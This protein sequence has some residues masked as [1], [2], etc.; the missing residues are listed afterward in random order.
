[1]SADY[2]P[3]TGA[4]FPYAVVVQHGRGWIY[5]HS[6]HTTEAEANTRARIT[7]EYFNKR[8]GRGLKGVVTVWQLIHS[9]S[10]ETPQAP[11]STSA[12]NSKEK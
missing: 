10:G 9:H 8:P 11:V 4:E 7:Q 3:I 1:M 6:R 2:T 5:F 12:A